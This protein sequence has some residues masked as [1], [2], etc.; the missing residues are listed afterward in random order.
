MNRGDSRE[1][2]RYFDLIEPLH[3]DVPS[4]EPVSIIRHTF[5]EG[6]GSSPKSYVHHD[7]EKALPHYSQNAQEPRHA[8]LMTARTCSLAATAH[9]PSYLSRMTSLSRTDAVALTTC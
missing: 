6:S 1:L 7:Q 8:V 3:F 2:E 4:I 5:S 9:A